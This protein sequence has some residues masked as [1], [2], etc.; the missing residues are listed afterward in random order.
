MSKM[1]L[2]Q[3]AAILQPTKKEEETGEEAKII[4]EPTTILAKDEKV[5]TMKV[6][7][8]IPPEYESKL[9]HIDIVIRPF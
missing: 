1:M 3:Y 9:E 6:V 8:K 4:I 7:R 2:F 5:V